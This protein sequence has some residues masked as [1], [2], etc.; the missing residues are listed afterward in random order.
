MRDQEL[1][2]E[3]ARV[4]RANYGVYGPAY[5]LLE[6]QPVRRPSEDYASSEKYEVRRWDLDEPQSIAPLLRRLK[7][8]GELTAVRLA[9]ETG[10]P[11]W[12]AALRLDMTAVMV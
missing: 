9:A 12:A 7:A 1:K 11:W 10:M 3:I 6:A 8:A 5:E 2:I 4:H